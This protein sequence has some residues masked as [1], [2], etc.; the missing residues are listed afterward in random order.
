MAIK[1]YTLMLF[2]AI[3]FSAE[4]PVQAES[5]RSM[6]MTADPVDILIGIGAAKYSVAVHKKV[7]ITVPFSFQYFAFYTANYSIKAGIGASFALSSKVFTD[8]WFIE[9]SLKIGYGEVVGEWH[10][11][12]S[13]KRERAFLLNPKLSAGYNWYWDSGFTL[14][15]GAGAVY[16]YETADIGSPYSLVFFPILPAVDF[17]L[18][19]SW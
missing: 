12:N 15:L 16:Q 4:T 5:A 13:P 18:G 8:G 19:Y 14:S 11:E 2:L 10:R 17:S 3:V 1:K 9:P 6:S 7:C